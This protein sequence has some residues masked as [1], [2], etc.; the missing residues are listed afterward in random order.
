MFPTTV[1]ITKQDKIAQIFNFFKMTLQ[2]IRHFLRKIKYILGIS[3]RK[4]FN[5]GRK[6]F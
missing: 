1:T 5:T 2:P 4:G 6:R 3:N